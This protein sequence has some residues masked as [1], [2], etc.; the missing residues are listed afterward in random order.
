MTA[1][2][3]MTTSGS[4]LPETAV[5]TARRPLANLNVEAMVPWIMSEKIW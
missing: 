3:R 4:Q 2:S 5:A 1:T